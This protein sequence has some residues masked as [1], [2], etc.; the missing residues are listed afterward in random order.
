[1]AGSAGAAMVGKEA[2]KQAT[3]LAFFNRGGD[4]LSIEVAPRFA[5]TSR[6]SSLDKGSI[7][8]LTHERN[9]Y[10]KL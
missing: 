9:I 6:A 3:V 4:L 7:G 1:M 2:E 10:F 5:G 8:T